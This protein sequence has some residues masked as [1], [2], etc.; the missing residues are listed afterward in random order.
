MDEQTQ[1]AVSSTGGWVF[2]GS[3]IFFFLVAG[4]LFYLVKV[5]GF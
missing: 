4:V 2:Y 1:E 5:A 3:V